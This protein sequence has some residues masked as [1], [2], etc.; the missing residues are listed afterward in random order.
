MK[1]I[2]EQ[3]YFNAYRVDSLNEA[4][5]PVYE[6]ELFHSYDRASRKTTV[7]ISHKHDE[8]NDLKGIIG[9]LEKNYNVKAYIDSKDNK[10]PQKTSSETA[11]RIKEKIKQCDKFILIATNGAIESKWCNW[12]LGYGD[13]QKFQ[14]NIAIFSMKPFC[15]QDSSYVGN[16]YMRIYPYIIYCDGSEKDTNDRN[17]KSGYYVCTEDDEG[18][19]NI[20]S[21][22]DWLSKR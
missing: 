11:S 2:F 19:M 12:E 3:G 9:F 4:T 5:Y 6:S 16:E 22:T 7:F 14:K 8:L 15:S 17:V 13:A 1:S 18:K 20:I 10:M 21:L